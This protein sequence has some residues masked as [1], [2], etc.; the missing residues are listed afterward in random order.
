VVDIRLGLSVQTVARPDILT[1]DG[2]F[3]IVNL[4]RRR[5]SDKSA[6]GGEAEARVGAG[7]VGREVSRVWRRS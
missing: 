6:D 4:K 1:P 7:E 5:R 3:V 2:Y